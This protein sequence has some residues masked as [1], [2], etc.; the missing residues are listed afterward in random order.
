MHGSRKIRT[1]TAPTSHCDAPLS[2]F[3]DSVSLYVVVF[4][5][6]R[7]YTGQNYLEITLNFKIIGSRRAHAQMT[8]SQDTME[9]LWEEITGKVSHIY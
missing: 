4:L 7:R 5:L 8:L 3:N 1:L 2:S 9:I 6:I